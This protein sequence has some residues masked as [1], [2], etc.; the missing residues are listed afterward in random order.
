MARSLPVSAGQ[1]RISGVQDFKRVDRLKAGCDAI[2]VG[3]GTVLA[4]DPSLTVKSEECLN[5]R[6]KQGWDDHPLRVVVDSS[7]A[8]PPTA[9]F[10]FK[11]EGKRVV[12]VSGRADAKKIAVLE[13]K[14]T[15][16][17]AGRD[18]VDLGILMDELGKVGVRRLMVEGGGT[19]IAGLMKA[20]LVNEIYSF[21][22]NII[23]GGKDAPTVADGEG[24]IKESEF[25]RLTLL[26]S[27][28]ID[29]GIL[30]HWKVNNPGQ[31]QE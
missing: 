25:A 1:V 26:E 4:D 30:L 19:L 14:A 20:G 12:A 21:I 3:I 28:R 24:F 31:M 8:T 22:G 18:E 5:Y 16:L 27:T 23:I 17:V 15:V 2:M 10:L 6:R 13:K 29:H 7:G 9:S 11:G